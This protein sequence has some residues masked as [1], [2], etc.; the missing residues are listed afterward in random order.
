MSLCPQSLGQLGPG[1]RS[2]CVLDSNWQ[3]ALDGSY[4]R[5]PFLDASGAAVP[6]RGTP[7]L[8]LDA[9]S[10]FAKYVLCRHLRRGER[11]H[12]R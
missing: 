11:H 6:G 1:P 3:A 12:S 8:K 5:A 9:E 4:R 2:Q 10:T 7:L